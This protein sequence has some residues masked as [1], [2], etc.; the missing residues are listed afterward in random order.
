MNRKGFFV[1]MALFV[2]VMLVVGG[3]QVFAQKKGDIVQVSGQT[4]RVTEYSD[5]RLV[6]QLVSLDG[7]WGETGAYGRVVTIKGNTGI[8]K[9]FSSNALIQS[10]VNKGYYTI[11]GQYFR[12]LTKTGDLTWSGQ[13]LGLTGS[14]SNATG[15]TW[16]D[17]T[18]TLSAD[19]QTLRL[20]VPG[21]SFGVN[22]TRR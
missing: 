7:V 12:N 13:E 5:G 6:M 1:M 11:G 21:Q 9:E 20:S 15:A 4:F 2:G 14:G 3:G 18:L 8:F 22:F 10:G 16:R 17:C 19:G